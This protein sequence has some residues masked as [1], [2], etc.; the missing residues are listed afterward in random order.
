MSWV[1]GSVA[2][3]SRII[4]LT[5]ATATGKTALSLEVARRTGAAI[6]SMDSR[7]VYRGMD[8]GTAKVTPEQRAAVPHFGIDVADPDERYGAGRF[9]RDARAW[10]KAI[11]ARG[12]PAI[13]TG[14][15]GFFLRALTHPLF[16]EPALPAERREALKRYLD[17]QAETRLRRWAGILEGSAELPRD[18]Q[19]L[20]RMIELG[21]LSG[22]PLHWWQRS[23][24]PSA[25]PL[26]V[27]VFVLEMQRDLLYARIEDRVHEMVRAGLEDEVRA[28][29]AA[30][31]GRG[32][33]GLD[34]TGYPEMI[35]F[36]EGELTLEGAVERTQAATRRYARRQMTWFRHQLP[37]ASIR[38]DAA[39]PIDVLAD[40]LINALE[41]REVAV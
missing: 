1:A 9:A 8:I 26:E 2:M 19:R 41:G 15:T 28:L 29:L 18:R 25:P 34:A 7:Q 5:G 24:P 31:Y 17:R 39:A 32:D 3:D 13:I 12:R 16:A 30:G 21:T 33:P 35:A 38:L 4:V 20:S 40:V 23:A 37:P 14:G 10:I 6:I 27:P 36:I 22:Y 11:A